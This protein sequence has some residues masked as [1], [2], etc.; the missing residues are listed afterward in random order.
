MAERDRAGAQRPGPYASLA[1]RHARLLERMLYAL[2]ALA[3]C[4]WVTH[5]ASARILQ[6]RL[7]R[8]LEEMRSESPRSPGPSQEIPEAPRSPTEARPPG[9]LVGRIDIPRVGVSSVILEG[10]DEHTLDLAV[11][12]LTETAELGRGNAALAGH[13]DS[14]FRGLRDVRP[15]DLV[16]VRTPQA[17]FQ[18]RIVWMKVTT[19]EDVYVLAAQEDDVLTLVT[20]FPFHYVGPA[21][22]RF[23][24][25]AARVEAISPLEVTAEEI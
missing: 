13:R 16:E 9:A 3:L 12:H 25:R 23:V 10:V 4:A 22:Q 1:R 8:M 14:F 17:D 18:Y 5:E 6:A 19:P 11:G 7:D 20:C 2:G 24:V 15:G 21:P